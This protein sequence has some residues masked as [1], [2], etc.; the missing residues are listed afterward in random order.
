[1]HNYMCASPCTNTVSASAF[2][3]RFVPLFTA[4]SDGLCNPDACT[5]DLMANSFWRVRKQAHCAL[6]RTR[7]SAA[8]VCKQ[9][10]SPTFISKL[11]RIVHHLTTRPSAPRCFLLSHAVHT[12]QSSSALSSLVSCSLLFRI[13]HN[14]CLSEVSNF[15]L[16]E[17]KLSRE[18]TKTF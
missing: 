12:T 6:L 14:D 10:I 1:M 9:S 5:R 17:T 11:R 8:H 4:V 16:L 13:V 18:F 15:N 2:D 7:L 3:V